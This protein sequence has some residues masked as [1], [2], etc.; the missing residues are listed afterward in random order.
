MNSAFWKHKLQSSTPYVPGEQPQDRAYIKLNTNES[1]YP[2]SPAVSTALRNFDI[3]SLR[4]YPDPNQMKLRSALAEQYMLS[5]DEVFVGNGSD[6]VLAFCF[7]AF[8]EDHTTDENAAVLTPAL[9]YS[10]YPVYAD[11]FAVPLEKIGLQ[12]DYSVDVSMYQRPSRAVILANPNAPTGL[13]LDNDAIRTL[14]E[15]D[16]Q[17]LVIVD[18]AYVDFAAESS[19][20]LLPDYDNLLVVQ[21]FSKS[22]A[23]AGIRLGY[24]LGKKNLIQGLEI[25]RDNINSYTVDRLAETLGMA[26]LADSH[27][28]AESCAKIVRTRELTRSALEKLGAAVTPSA[29]NFLW[30]K[31]PH[32]SGKDVYEQLKAQGILVRYFKQ[33]GLEDHVRVTIGTDEEMALF[34]DV[35][36]KL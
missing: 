27:Y 18:E 31:H 33:V 15:Q 34:L 10:F 25:V 20:S 16:R 29:A 35:F 14:L 5:A 3:A 9:G 26:S 7:Q 2:P 11:F 6:E 8:F 32:L 28:F 12:E 1:P 19:A 17:R 23:L 24:A 13:Y 21:T 4:L 22:R 30:L 36:A